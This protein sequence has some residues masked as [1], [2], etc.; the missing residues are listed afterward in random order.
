[1]DGGR[2]YLLVW[3]VLFPNHLWMIITIRYTVKPTG[4]K[5]RLIIAIVA[6]TVM[7][8]AADKG[9]NLLRGTRL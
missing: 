2:W 3:T 7:E 6:I 4:Q 8:L 1:M 9:F 5:I